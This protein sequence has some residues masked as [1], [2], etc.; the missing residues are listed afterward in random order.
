MSTIRWAPEFAGWGVISRIRMLKQSEE[1][2]SERARRERERERE[3]EKERERERK[4]ESESERERERQRK[5][6]RKREKERVLV[7]QKQ[8]PAKP[9]RTAQALLCWGPGPKRAVRPCLSI[10][11]IFMPLGD[12]LVRFA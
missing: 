7:D 3:T 10:E 4:R 8:T 11:A 12:L 1:K 5:R 9:L 6:Q 2:L